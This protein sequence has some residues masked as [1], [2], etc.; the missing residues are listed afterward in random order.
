MVG[1]LKILGGLLLGLIAGGAITL[2]LCLLA[3]EIF[4]I[5]QMEGAYAMGVVFFWTPAGALLGAIVGAIW[6]AMRLGRRRA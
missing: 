3:A 2:A 1:F 4:N 5:S 6:V